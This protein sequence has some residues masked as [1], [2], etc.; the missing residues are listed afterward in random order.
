KQ[1]VTRPAPRRMIEL[2]HES[3]RRFAPWGTTCVVE[4]GFEVTDIPGLYFSEAGAYDEELI[5]LNRIRTVLDP[6]C[7]ARLA[8]GLA[9][10]VRTLPEGDLDRNCNFDALDERLAVPQFSDFPTGTPR[11]DRFQPPELT[12][13]DYVRLQRTLE[14]R[15]HRRRVFSPR[16]LRIFVD[17]VPLASFE[18]K[19]TRSVRHVIGA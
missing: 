15:L 3:L 4:S 1:F 18:P 12:R 5:E 19:T 13:E 17:D 6:A 2:V 11:G 9:Q 14:A 7:F 10:Y 8:A 16:E